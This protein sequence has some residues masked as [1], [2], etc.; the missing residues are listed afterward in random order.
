MPTAKPKPKTIDEYISAYPENVQAVLQ[1]LRQLVKEV[2]PDCKEAIKYG[3]PTFVLHGNLVYFGA[4]KN[5]IGFYPI[6]G[7]MEATIEELAAY[8]T[9]GKGTI[10]FPYSKPLPLPL[11]RKIIEMRVQENTA[12]KD[13][14][15]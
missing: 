4:W 1:T 8:N 11:I 5:H 10:Q 14:S 6:T 9:S 7:E 13:K 3:M 12:N 2:A 15:K